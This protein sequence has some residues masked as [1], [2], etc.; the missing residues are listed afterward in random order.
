MGR[1]AVVDVTLAR[2]PV[3]LVL[4]RLSLAVVNIL[5]SGCI[6]AAD[7][8]VVRS[9]GLDR[10]RQSLLGGFARPQDG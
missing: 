1:V 5:S 4:N 9:A 6:P 8:P 10:C 2:C 3:A 7:P